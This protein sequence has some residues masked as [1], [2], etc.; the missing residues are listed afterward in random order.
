MHEV[1]RIYLLEETIQ[2]QQLIISGL[3][4]EGA[5][6]SSSSFEL[7]LKAHR[8]LTNKPKKIKI[9]GTNQ[10]NLIS[11]NQNKLEKKGDSTFGDVDVAVYVLVQRAA[12]VASQL[13]VCSC[14]ARQ[15][16][17]FARLSQTDVVMG[18]RS[19]PSRV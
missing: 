16:F 10:S 14:F 4:G 19:S 1:S 7:G 15:F 6:L 5:N 11:T 9:L 18:A 3:L 8:L 12:E 2:L 17:F 13:H